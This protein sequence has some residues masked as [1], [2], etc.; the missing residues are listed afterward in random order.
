MSEPTAAA[1]NPVSSPL[2]NAKLAAVA[3]G[4]STKALAHRPNPCASCPFGYSVG[5]AI[6]WRSPAASRPAR[7][8]EPQMPIR[9]PQNDAR[10]PRSQHEH[11]H[12]EQDDEGADPDELGG[13]DSLP[14]GL[15][16][17][18]PGNPTAS[19]ARTLPNAVPVALSATRFVTH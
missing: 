9:L 7:V 4:P 3:E 12:E 18:A 10:R 8:V 19:C 6:H 11:K 13:P 1:I 14:V 16:V 15:R 2:A 5:K 17:E